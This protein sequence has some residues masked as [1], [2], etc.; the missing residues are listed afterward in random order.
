MLVEKTSYREHTLITISQVLVEN[1][2]Y[3]EHILLTSAQVLVLGELVLHYV[4][5][6]HNTAC[7]STKFST[8]TCAKY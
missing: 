2:S 4:V 8:T 6:R 5:P 1:T 3:R 7:T